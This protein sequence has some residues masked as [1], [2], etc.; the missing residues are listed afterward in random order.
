MDFLPS[1]FG[2]PKAPSGIWASCIR[3]LDP[4]E[5]K[6]LA[7]VHL[8]NNE[9]AFSIAI[10]PFAAKNNE[11]HLVVGT[12]ANTFIAPRSCSSGYLRTYAFT[13][14]GAGIELLHKVCNLQ[15]RTEL[16]IYSILD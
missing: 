14:D 7:Q 10:V 5:G 16:A 1:S 15:S 3:I 2:F 13:N 4:V 11:L 6:T 9:A 12:A 8:D